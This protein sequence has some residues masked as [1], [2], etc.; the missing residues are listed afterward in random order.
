M[1]HEE[2]V[3]VIEGLLRHLDEGTNVDAGHQLR[4][5]VSAYTC[6]DLAAREWESF[7]QGHPQVLGLSADLPEPRSFFTSGDLGKPILCTRADDGEFRAF[8][9]VCRHRGTIVEDAERG[10]RKNFQCPFHAWTYDH[11]GALVGV[12]KESHF[13]KVDRECNSLVSLPAV[14]RYGLL[15][16][17]PEPGATFDLD[18]LLGD[19]APELESWG[20]ERC[21]RHGGVRYDHPM[22]WKLAI[23]TFGETY[24][25]NAL[26]RNTLANDFYGNVQMYDTYGRNHRMALCMK[27]IDDLRT[28][29]RDEWNV[30][31]GALPVYYLFPNVQLIV[32]GPGPTLVRVYPDGPDANQSFSQVGF[33]IFPEILENEGARAF[34]ERAGM[35]VEAMLVM[36]QQG[37][38]TIIQAEDYVAAASGHRGAQS[39]ALEHVTFGRNEPALHHYH[40]TYREALGME[41]LEVVEAAQDL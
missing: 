5:P 8:L 40:N 7:F 6:G 31:Q 12:P 15:W 36:R 16:V 23:D 28:K 19:L 10:T 2:Q 32:G 22:N 18:A 14:E 30:L 3:R 21:V 29:P 33:Y 41:P 20:L 39:G 37:F 27:S 24:H 13:G 17:S 34:A 4:N 26:H 11:Q 35:T 1:R 25:F 9:N 38:A